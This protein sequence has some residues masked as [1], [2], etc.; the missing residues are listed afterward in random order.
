[1]RDTMFEAE[2]DK[3]NQLFCYPFSRF[4]NSSSATVPL[5]LASLIT[6]I[7]LREM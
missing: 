6:L 2:N 5:L 7:L 1:M 4:M 3:I